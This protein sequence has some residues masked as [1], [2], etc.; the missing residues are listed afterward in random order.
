[1]QGI[2]EQSYWM[3]DSTIITLAFLGLCALVMGCLA[4]LIL[5]GHDGALVKAMIG[6]SVAVFGGNFFHLVKRRK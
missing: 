6:I 3:K 4:L 5:C 2:S 1:M